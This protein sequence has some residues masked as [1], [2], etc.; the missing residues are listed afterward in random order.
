MK[1]IIVML[2][3]FE[4][5]IDSNDSIVK[6]KFE[7]IKTPANASLVKAQRDL[8][9]I[10]P[11]VLDFYEAANGLAVKWKAKDAKML[12]NEMMGSVK[13]NSFINVVKDW[14]GV[15]FFGSEPD[16]SPLLEFFPLDFFADEA[17]VGFC[18]QEGWRNSLY[19]YRFDNELVSLQVTFHAYLQ[20]LLRPKELFTGNIL[21]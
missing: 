1:D 16:D 15:V 21:S 7:I 20:L 12:A 3:A 17:T 11:T 19:L 8:N 14:S 2:A 10:E 9:M 18:T 4:K 13:I 6:E 5:E